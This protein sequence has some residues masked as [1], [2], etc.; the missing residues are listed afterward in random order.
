MVLLGGVPFRT[1]HFLEG[2]LQFSDGHEHLF[3]S[4]T[5]EFSSLAV[6]DRVGYDRYVRQN[7][8]TF[9]MCFSF[10]WVIETRQFNVA[11]R[12]TFIP[13]LSS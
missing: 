11:V 2:L 7:V 9:L 8:A 12:I 6:R 13:V 10:E 4:V 3:H 5:F 1:F